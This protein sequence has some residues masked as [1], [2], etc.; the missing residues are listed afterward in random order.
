MYLRRRVL[1]L[2]LGITVLA[3]I[4]LGV[5]TIAGAF[6]G[7]P[8]LTAEQL[9]VAHL[10]YRSAAERDIA[11]LA[12]ANVAVV[13]PARPGLA[14]PPAPSTLFKYPLSSHVVFGYLPYWT[15]S[16]LSSA[17]IAEV[18]TLSYFGL[19][20]DGQGGVER[21]GSG[22]LDLSSQALDSVILQ[23]HN[24]GDK[25]LLTISTTSM[26]T[27]DA[28]LANPRNAGDKLA[29]S[30]SGLVAA[31]GFDGIDV[32]IE[33]R[34]Q[35]D[36]SA[37]VTFFDELAR[38]FRADSP[39]HEVV[40]N[41]YPQSAAGGKDFFDVAR[42]AKSADQLFVMAYDMDSHLVASANDPLVAPSL[43]LSDVQSMMEY[44]RVVPRQKIVLG[45]PFYGYDFSTISSEKG[46]AAT[47]ANPEAVLYSS[48]ATV[49][50]PSVW[51]P[52]TATPYSTFQI[53][54]QWHQTWYDDPLSLAIRTALAAD[55]G[56]AGVGSWALGFEGGHE[57]LLSA[58]TGDAP[59]RR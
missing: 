50:H 48:I 20:L 21:S 38:A 46:A 34:G 7:P 26:Q 27:I 44:T 12:E 9:A 36:R 23:A 43:G 22:W 1:I 18:S 28:L 10:Q 37:F 2:A 3:G 32:D 51:D 55:F 59:P 33:G 8:P 17:D 29:Q 11:R 53:S 13:L 42:L 39:A 25:V 52:L 6:A 58:L 54:G 49:G 41:T 15:L 5:A 35:Q 14:A 45:M 57:Q 31:H 24:A 19:T 47:T 4:G 16:E 30:L 40:L 56:I